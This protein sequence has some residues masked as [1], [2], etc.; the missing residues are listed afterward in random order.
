MCGQ[1]VR[2]DVVTRTGGTRLGNVSQLWVDT[3]EW[4]VIALDCRPVANGVL[5]PVSIIVVQ[6][7]WVGF[8]S[9]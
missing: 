4:E 5:S 6:F 3:D 2:K 8:R 1:L 9:R 7:F